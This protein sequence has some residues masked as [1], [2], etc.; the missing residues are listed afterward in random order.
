MAVQLNLEM[1]KQYAPES[2]ILAFTPLNSGSPMQDWCRH[3]QRN[4]LRRQ[5]LEEFAILGDVVV[6]IADEIEAE[7]VDKVKILSLEYA[8]KVLGDEIDALEFVR[9]VRAIASPD[10]G[11]FEL[12]QIAS[13]YYGEIRRRGIP[14]VLKEMGMLGMQMSAVTAPLSERELD[15]FESRPILMKLS[16][17]DKRRSRDGAK[18]CL[19][20]PE[21]TPNFDAEMDSVMRRI[22]RQ[23]ITRMITDEFEEYYLSDGD[24]SL[25]ELDRDF[26]TFESLDQYD[27]NGTINIRMNGGQSAVV[28]FDFECEVDASYLPSDVRGLGSII[29]HLFVGHQMGGTEAGKARMFIAESRPEMIPFV[30]ATEAA[31]R[32]FS[33]NEFEEW[34]TLSLERIYCR[35]VVRTVRKIR[36]IR[37]STVEYL[38]ENEINPDYDEMQ[39]VAGVCRVLWQ[40]MRGDFHIRS[41]RNASYQDLYL[42]LRGTTDTAVVAELK[43]TAFAAYKERKEISLKEFTALNT[44]AKSQEARLANRISTAARRW[45]KTIEEV[46]MGRLRFLKFALYN[47]PEAKRFTRQEKQSLWDSVRNRESELKAELNAKQSQQLL[48]GQPAFVKIIHAA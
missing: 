38:S 29:S 43:R 28:A 47:D 23:K 33:D 17:A 4:P 36:S 32:P 16:R 8:V 22:G 13:H 48:F 14:E 44:V 19:P 39:Y 26:L 27:E 25:E 9:C 3:L 1:L 10:T 6:R 30:S 45:I 34:L 31:K 35:Q 12:Q 11:Q 21:P 15:V 40:K 37:N 2:P 41:L 46:S 18:S 5:E 7:P 20:L 42:S 24:K